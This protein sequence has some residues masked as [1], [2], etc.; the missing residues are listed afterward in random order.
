M[1]RDV[2]IKVMTPELADDEQ[3]VAASSTKPN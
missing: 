1:N 3:F 2:A